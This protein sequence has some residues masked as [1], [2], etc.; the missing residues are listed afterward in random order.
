MDRTLDS[1]ITEGDEHGRRAQY[2]IWRPQCGIWNC[3][4]PPNFIAHRPQTFWGPSAAIAVATTDMVVFALEI[5]YI[6]EV[7]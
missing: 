3:L 2:G 5:E 7:L 6:Y 1:V 4:L